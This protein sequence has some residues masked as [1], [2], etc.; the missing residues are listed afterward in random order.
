MLEITLAN[1]FVPGTNRKG[2]LVGA[3]WL[4]LRPDLAARHAL[5]LGEP[6][7]AARLALESL[8]DEVTVVADGAVPAALGSRL[9][10][11]DRGGRAAERPPLRP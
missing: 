2:A 1:E 5:C 7:P 8:S 3:N 4:F 11:P 6:S 9:A 10:R